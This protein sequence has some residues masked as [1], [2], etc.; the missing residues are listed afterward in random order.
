MSKKKTEENPAVLLGRK[1]WAGVS[2][3]DRSTAMTALASRRSAALTPER[4]SEIA[5]KAA[6][7]R[8]AKKNSE[9]S[10]KS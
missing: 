5:R 10:S 2:A 7:A 4:R 8:H 3:A 9:K 1:R 6:A